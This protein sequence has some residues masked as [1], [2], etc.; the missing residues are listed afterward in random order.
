MNVPAFWALLAIAL[1]FWKN[2]NAG[3]ERLRHHDV[4]EL[5]Y[6]K[7]HDRTLRCPKIKIPMWTRPES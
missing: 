5:P 2:G 7:V 1:P 6:L 3:K 4:I